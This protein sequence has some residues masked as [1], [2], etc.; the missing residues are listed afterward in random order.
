MSIFLTFFL[1]LNNM[2][3]GGASTGH[4]SAGLWSSLVGASHQPATPGSTCRGHDLH[5]AG[6]MA[7]GIA[8]GDRFRHC[9]T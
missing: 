6:I 1:L 9:R 5:R 4:S 2:F 8:I 3:G 7:H